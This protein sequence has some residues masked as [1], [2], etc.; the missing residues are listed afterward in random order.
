MYIKS[1]SFFAVGAVGLLVV[2]SAVA[3]MAKITPPSSIAAGTDA[4]ELLLLLLLMAPSNTATV[5]AT[6]K[7]SAFYGG[8]IY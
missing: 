4:D 5:S 7:T 6:G 3:T 2:A 1:A 8:S